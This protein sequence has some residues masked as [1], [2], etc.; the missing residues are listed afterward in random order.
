MFAPTRPPTLQ[1]LALCCIGRNYCRH[2]GS[3]L[4]SGWASG[5]HFSAA[6]PKRS[7][8]VGPTGEAADPSGREDLCE[9]GP[10][11]SEG[12][13]MVLDRT[14]WSPS[15]GRNSWDA[16]ATRRSSREA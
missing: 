8:N 1:Q 3:G 10:R 11:A 4:L 7:G 5:R 15:H 16:S 2:R 9:P 6:P 13:G 14:R 12:S